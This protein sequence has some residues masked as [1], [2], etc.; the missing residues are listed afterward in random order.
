MDYREWF[1]NIIT[2]G[3]LCAEYTDKYHN[4]Q[5]K[6]QLVDLA[7]GGRGITYLCEMREKGY[8]A[9][10]DML[11]KQFGPYLNSKYIFTSGGEHPYTSC[12]YVSHNR[13]IDVN[14]TAVVL[15]GCKA[16]VRIHDYTCVHLF[17]DG[18][19]ELKIECARTSKCYVDY[20]GDAKFTYDESKKNILFK[21][22]S[23]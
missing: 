14:T 11:I 12:I 6:K 2:Q 20:W 21:N 15:L 13:D 17:V 1:D 5:S 7:L 16:T 19:C 23:V 4:A 3:Q 8:G 18:G 22:K 9:P 10:Y